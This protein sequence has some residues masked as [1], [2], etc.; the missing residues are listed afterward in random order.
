MKFNEQDHIYYNDDGEVFLGSTSFIKRFCKPFDKQKI[1]AKYAKKHKRTVKDVLDEWEKKSSDAI[2]KGLAFHKMK[3][4]QLNNKIHLLIEDE[5]HPI[6]KA[7][8]INGV[9]INDTLK[10]DPGVYPELI[11]WSDKY[12]IAGQADYVEITK[13]G[14]ININDY[15]TSAEIKK[16]GYRKWD[17]SVDTMQFPLHNLQDCNFIHYSLQLNLYAFLIKQHNRKLKIG[18]MTV[19]HIK[20]DFNETT[21]TFSNI[22]SEFHTVPD[23]QDDVKILLEYYRNSKN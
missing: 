10:L 6:V 12:G 17:G 2:V 9:K 5:D 1:A 15:K 22:H 20:G 7:S 14:Y 23:M 21:G 4:D 19:E 8:W 16:E 18:K 3:E 13:K 11:V